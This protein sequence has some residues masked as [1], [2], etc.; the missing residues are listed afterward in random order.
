MVAHKSTTFLF[1]SLGE[2]GM[3]TFGTMNKTKITEIFNLLKAES[4]ED[5]AY[6]GFF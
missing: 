5:N 4:N 6:I 3:I 1:L 2:I